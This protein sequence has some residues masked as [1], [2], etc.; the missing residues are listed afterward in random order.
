MDVPY[1]QV[2]QTFTLG[3][4]QTIRFKVSDT[5][6]GNFVNGSIARATVTYPD[7]KTVRQFSGVTDT[8]GQVKFTWRIENNAKPG[9]FSV[10][11]QVS[12]PGFESESFSAS[13]ILPN[14]RDQTNDQLNSQEFGNGTHHHHW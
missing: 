8:T 7:G 1:S 13:F 3:D 11:A 5:K 4:T 10:S 14:T 9:T 2:H 6:T 12:A